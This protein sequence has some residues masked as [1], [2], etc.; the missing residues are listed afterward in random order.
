MML[1]NTPYYVGVY[2]V[3]ELDY[4]YVYRYMKREDCP[5]VKFRDFRISLPAA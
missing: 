5:K 1:M 4:G 3:I 2:G